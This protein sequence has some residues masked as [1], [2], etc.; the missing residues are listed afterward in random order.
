MP[1]VS[2]KQ[3]GLIFSK[4]NKYGTKKNTPKK[5]K[6][7]WDEGWENKGELPETSESKLP[8]FT[9]F[10]KED[11]K[12]VIQEDW[13]FSGLVEVIIDGEKKWIPVYDK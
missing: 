10:I 1:A 6:W 4:R 3:R 7:I 9:D 5:F 12:E 2:Q 13:K 8:K 11:K